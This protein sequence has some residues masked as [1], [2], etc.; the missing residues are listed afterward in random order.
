MS[1]HILKWEQII[2]GGK[3][4]SDERF[5]MSWN[6]CRRR[7]MFLFIVLVFHLEVCKIGSSSEEF[8]TSLTTMWR[9]NYGS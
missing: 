7:F 5:E 2:L 6:N 4:T 8:C 1:I 3:I 9:N